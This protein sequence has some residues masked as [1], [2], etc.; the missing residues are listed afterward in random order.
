MRT[1]SPTLRLAR[2]VIDRAVASRRTRSLMTAPSTASSP[3]SSPR[4][5]ASTTAWT[6]STPTAGGAGFGC[7]RRA[8]RAMAG[9]VYPRSRRYRQRARCCGWQ[10]G[11]AFE[12]LTEHGQRVPAVLAGGGEI[13]AQGQERLGPGRGAPA[14]RDLLLQLDHPQVAFGLVVVER[15]AGVV[16]RPQH[17]VP[18]GIQPGQQPGCGRTARTSWSSAAG[19]W[20]WVGRLPVGDEP[21]I[22]GVQ[23]GPGLVVD[24]TGTH[25]TGPVAGQ[26]G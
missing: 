11:V 8:R 5:I 20:G 19:R 14:A 15:H 16:Q 25:P 26:L 3:S 21:L 23:P 22:S 17:L 13:A 18:V 1:R 7:G 12:Q 9:R 4:A 10:P 24:P 6:R 2:V